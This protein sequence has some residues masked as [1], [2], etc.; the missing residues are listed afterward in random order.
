MNSELG[1]KELYEVSIK[2]TL[3]IE[4]GGRIIE[5]GET[6]ASFD[7]IQIANFQ[8]IKDVVSAKG[9]YGNQSL[10][11]WDSTKEVRISFTQGIFSKIQ[12]ALMTNSKLIE[13]HGKQVVPIN[14]REQHEIDENGK[15]F[16][17]HYPNGIVFI[18]DQTTGEKITDAEINGKIIELNDYT[19][20]RD[21]VVDYWYN[22]ENGFTTLTVGQRLTCGH[23]SLTGKMKV[24]DDITGKVRTGII[25]IP[26]MRLM[27]DLSMRVGS[28]AIPQTG[29]LDAVAEPEGPRNQQKVMEI[30]FLNDDIDADM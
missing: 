26:K 18:Y 6:I 21:V 10:V 15:I 29:R 16:L 14:T 1:F 2:A 5:A 4:V 3:P 24:K 19:K 13:N 20:Y 11:T 8:E 17:D 7:K 28:D 22:Y 9:G 23:L 12:L 25:R 30:I 27:S